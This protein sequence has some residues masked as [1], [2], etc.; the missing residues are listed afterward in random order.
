MDIVLKGKAGNVACFLR[1]APES[2]RP[3]R[4]DLSEIRSGVWFDMKE[5]ANRGRPRV[6]FDCRR[7]N[8]DRAAASQLHGP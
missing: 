1:R 4:A 7:R 5:A 2:E 8:S 3:P 6:S